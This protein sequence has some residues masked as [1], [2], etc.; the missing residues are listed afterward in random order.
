MFL[1][2]PERRLPRIARQFLAYTQSADA[3]MAIRQAGYVDQAPETMRIGLQGDRLSN[4]C[5]LGRGRG[6]AGRN[7]AHDHHALRPLARLS[8][9]VRFEPGSSRPDAQSRSN[10]LY[11]A[12]ALET[13]AP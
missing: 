2:L 9:S 4:A 11:L 12:Q 10:I 3:Q 8:L 1:Y 13:G 5:R 6:R 7:A